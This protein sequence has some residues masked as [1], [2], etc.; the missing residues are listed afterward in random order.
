MLIA[1]TL[2]SAPAEP[3]RQARAA[4]RIERAAKASQADWSKSERRS[5]RLILDELGRP[6]RLRLIEL[7]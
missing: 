4:V 1:Q 3:Q 2:S 6:L 7:E 5:E